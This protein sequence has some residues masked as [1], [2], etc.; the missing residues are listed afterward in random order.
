MLDRQQLLSKKSEEMC[1]EYSSATYRRK[2]HL[3]I[4]PSQIKGCFLVEKTPFSRCFLSI[5]TKFIVQKL[6]RLW[7]LFYFHQTR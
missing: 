1:M 4:F 6:W 7:V 2:T 5:A 3:L